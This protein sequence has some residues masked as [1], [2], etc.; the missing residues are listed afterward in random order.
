M[1][2]QTIGGLLDYAA[3]AQLYRP[4]DP[5]GLAQECQRL[6]GMGWTPRDISQSLRM[7]LREVHELL[8]VARP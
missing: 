4:I 6:S 2:H 3:L 8:A 1:K 7:E 5:Q